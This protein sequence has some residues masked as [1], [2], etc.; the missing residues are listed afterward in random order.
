MSMLSKAIEKYIK[1]KVKKYGRNGAIIWAVKK[2]VKMTPTKTDDLM[3]VAV[4]K[5]INQ[6]K[7][8]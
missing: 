3:L 6:F 5:T 7:E 2:I 8:T 1:G 4:E